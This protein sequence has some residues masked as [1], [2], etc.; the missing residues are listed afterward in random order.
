MH[1]SQA[2]AGSTGMQRQQGMGDACVGHQ[3]G[4]MAGLVVL[5]PVSSIIIC[6]QWTPSACM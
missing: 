1:V 2:V 4:H 5:T 3:Q 6:A